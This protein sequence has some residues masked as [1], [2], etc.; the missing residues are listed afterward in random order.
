MCASQPSPA[1]RSI[2]KKNV[3]ANINYSR[4]LFIRSQI[5]A[6][7]KARKQNEPSPA[8]PRRSSGPWG[9]ERRLEFIDFRLQWD[10]RLNRSDLMGHFGISVPQAS[11]DIAAY[12][13]VAPENLTYDRSAR[14]YVATASYRPAFATSG[15]E[16]YLNDLLTLS[17]GVLSREGS[18][19]GWAPSVAL[20]AAPIRSVPSTVLV[21]V[22][23]AI[24]RQTSVDVLYQSMSRPDPSWRRISPHALGHDGFRWHVRAYCHQR[25][26]FRD[27]V[28]ARAIEIR[29]AGPTTIQGAGDMA[30]HSTVKLM[31]AP[32]A[33][34]SL[35]KRRVVELDYAMSGGQVVLET[36]QAMLYYALQRLG[37]S[38]D[39]ELQPKAQQIELTNASEVKEILEGLA[40]RY[41]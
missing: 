24:R 9:Q 34:L 21:S 33:G 4:T 7:M 14:V 41:D 18:F 20:A 2:G 16:N 10:G 25:E 3:C 39:G 12:S 32:T 23:R 28:F 22:V 38:R 13:D 36:R 1:V 37:L 17:S 19:V 11:A 26:T 6:K 30:W 27:F 31:L 5:Q 29:D 35:S 40:K 8:E 15:A